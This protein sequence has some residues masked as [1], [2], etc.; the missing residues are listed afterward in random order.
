MKWQ[1][2]EGTDADLIAARN[3][4]ASDSEQAA[5][6]FLDAVFE[7]FDLLGD[8]PEM[9]PKARF[10]HPNLKRVRY[11]LLPPPFNRW[12]IFYLPAAGGVNI[13]RVLYGN[14]NWRD[15]PERLF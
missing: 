11:F 5:V 9:G 10:K 1:A 12:I 13:R 4:I 8:F 6:D 14:I 2:S 3:F 15:E 7:T